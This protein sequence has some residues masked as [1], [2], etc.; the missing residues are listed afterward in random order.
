MHVALWGIGG[1]YT[2][3][4]WGNLGERDHLEDPR[5]DG[6]IILSWI[7]RKW[8]V[9]AWNGLMWLRIETDGGYL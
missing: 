8:G 5:T 2:G 3:F 1:I 9:E 6:M 7:F 4:W